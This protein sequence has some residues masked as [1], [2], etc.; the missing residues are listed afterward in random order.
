PDIICMAK[1]LS[2]GY[3]P[4]AATLCRRR[5]AEA[6]EGDLDENRTLYHGHTFTGNPLAC[7]AA[8]ASLD[9]FDRHD[10]L[11]RVRLHESRIRVALETLRDHPHVRDVRQRGVMVGVELA[12]DR[13]SGRPFDPARRVPHHLC[14][15]MRRAGLM[16]RPLGDVIILMPAPAMDDTTLA[17]ALAIFVRTLEGF[18]FPSPG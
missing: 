17:D 12:A 16:V 9:L 14:L 5:I 18:D 1:G 11:T 10:I 3:L 4:L 7:A 8:L 6:F 13:A 2:G 15:A